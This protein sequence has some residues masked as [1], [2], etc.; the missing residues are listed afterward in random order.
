MC[1]IHKSLQTPPSSVLPVEVGT[2][3]KGVP[4]NGKSI[5]FFLAAK[6]AAVNENPSPI[7]ISGKELNKRAL[8]ENGGFLQTSR[9]STAE[10][11]IEQQQVNPCLNWREDN[12]GVI[13]FGQVCSFFKKT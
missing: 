12:S 1:I 11:S 8:Q 9:S 2:G 13:N 4:G 3:K 5:F 6:F 10:H 7:H